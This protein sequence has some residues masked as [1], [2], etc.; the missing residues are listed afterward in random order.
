MAK[1]KKKSPKKEQKIEDK[2]S[3]SRVAYMLTSIASA[4]LLFTGIV[5]LSS[6]QRIV[7][8]MKQYEVTITY[9]SIVT[10]SIIWFV[11]AFLLWFTA[12]KIEITELKSEK[13][14]L[15]ALSLITIFSGSL[16]A[17]LLA[18]IASIIY[19]RQK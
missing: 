15:F 13:W 12:R 3:K 18:L 16:V 6:K 5:F 9:S 7:E 10:Y 2:K 11:L 19:L 8:M 1:T 14:L 4:F 17:G